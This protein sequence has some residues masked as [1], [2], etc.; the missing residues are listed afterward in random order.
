MRLITLKLTMEELK[1]LSTLAADQ[2]FRKEFIDSK[3]PGYKCNRLEI[4]AGKA[5]VQRLQVISSPYSVRST[6]VP[7]TNGAT[8]QAARAPQ[9]A[10]SAIPVR[11]T[12]R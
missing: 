7:K 11:K 8:L 12:H 5:L 4:T 1:L 3:M 10:I 2:L 9:Q 6:P